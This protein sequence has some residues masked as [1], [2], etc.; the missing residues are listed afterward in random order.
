MGLLDLFRKKKSKPAKPA[1]GEYPDSWPPELKMA[2]AM[3]HFRILNDSIELIS[4]TVYPKTFFYRYGLAVQEAKIVAKLSHGLKNEQAAQDILCTLQEEKKNIVNS[5]LFRCYDSEKWATV[6]DDIRAHKDEMPNESFELFSTMVEYQDLLI[7]D[8][9]DLNRTRLLGSAAIAALF[10]AGAVI[11]G[12]TSGHDH[13]RY[14]NGD[15]NNC[16]PHYGYR[17]GRWYYGHGHQSGCERG[18][19]GGRTG[20]TYRD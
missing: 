10:V 1:Y 7:D 5:F 13:S 11:G 16:P 6:K 14:C 19:N 15:C 8:H 3:Q 12:I 2:Q 4:K 18:G 17:Y 9:R 20:K